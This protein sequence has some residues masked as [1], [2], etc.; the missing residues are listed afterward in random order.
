MT[1]GSPGAGDGT[2]KREKR[3]IESARRRGVRMEHADRIINRPIGSKVDVPKEDKL[4]DWQSV[5]EDPQALLDKVGQR[6]L[7]IGPQKAALE[8][9]KWDA[10]MQQ[11]ARGD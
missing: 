8:M 10:E 11:L 6:S 4:A 1:F 3:I 9:L 5:V 2:A 7:A